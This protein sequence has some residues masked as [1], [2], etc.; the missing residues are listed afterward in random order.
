[1]KGSTAAFYIDIAS[2]LSDDKG[3][4]DANY[5]TDGIHLSAAGYFV[6]SA[7]L[8]RGSRMMVQF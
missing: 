2:K 5:T 6:W 7:E 3:D 8:A 4:L 1:M